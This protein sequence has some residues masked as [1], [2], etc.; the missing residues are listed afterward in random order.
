MEKLVLYTTT[1]THSLG[2]K[3]GVIL[4]LK[5]R[6]LQVTAEDNF[7]LRGETLEVALKE[8][9]QAGLHPFILSMLCVMNLISWDSCSLS[10][11]RYGWDDI[12]GCCR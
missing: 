12:F 8:D 3:A 6:T 9:A 4:G 7:A 11:S 2:K 10:C 5:V 1:Q